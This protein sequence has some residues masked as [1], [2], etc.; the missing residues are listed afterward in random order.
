MT[1]PELDD[2]LA[3]AEALVLPP[4][5]DEALVGYGERFHDT[6]AIYDRERVLA[7]L[8]RNGGLDREAAAE[9]FD[10][11]IL[12]GWLGSGTAAFVTL[13]DGK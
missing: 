4:E 7:V 11:N 3:Q 9:H 6:F 8:M 2:L 12:G 13:L 1:R 10:F 5:F